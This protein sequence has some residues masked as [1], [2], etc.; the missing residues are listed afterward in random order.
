[1]FVSSPNNPSC[2]PGLLDVILNTN[3]PVR[4]VGQFV[5]IKFLSQPR[6][7]PAPG[8][9]TLISRRVGVVVTS[10]TQTRWGVRAN[11]LFLRFLATGNEQRLAFFS[12]E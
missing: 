6:F 2:Q 12:C 9:P 8:I 1:M 3:P 7:T 5:D 11:N 4:S 10:A